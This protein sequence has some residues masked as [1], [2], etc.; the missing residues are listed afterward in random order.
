ML[1]SLPLEI[2]NRILFECDPIDISSFSQVCRL[3]RNHVYGVENRTH[4]WHLIFLNHFDPSIY[5]LHQ[6]PV[7]GKGGEVEGDEDLMLK[8]RQSSGLSLQTNIDWCQTVQRRIKLRQTLSCSDDKELLRRLEKNYPAGSLIEIYQEISQ[9]IL[10]SKID[11]QWSYSQDPENQLSQSSLNLTFLRNILSYPPTQFRIILYSGQNSQNQPLFALR[12]TLNNRLVSLAAELHTKYGLTDFDRNKPR[13]RG[14]ARESC[15]ALQN[16]QASSLYGPFMPDRSCRVNWAHLE[17]LSVVVGL[18]LSLAKTSQ[19]SSIEEVNRHVQGHGRTEV[20]RTTG[21]QQFI[22]NNNHTTN[23]WQNNPVGLNNLDQSPDGSIDRRFL[24]TDWPILDGLS[25]ARPFTQITN[26]AYQHVA[27]DWPSNELRMNRALD[28]NHYDWA[29]VEGKWLRAVCFLDYRDLHAYNFGPRDT[30]KVDNYKEAIRLM[31]L[32]LKVVSIG[33]RP[34]SDPSHPEPLCLQ[35][36]PQY[37]PPIYFKGSATSSV[38]VGSQ[39]GQVRGCV[40]CTKDKQVRWS[41]VRTAAGQDRWSSEGIQVGGIRSK[42]GVLGVWTDVDRNDV[43]GPA[44]PFY[45]F[46]ISY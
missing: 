26:P 3:T 23:P 34:A 44:G 33:E 14:I 7:M 38:N 46:K 27:Y 25:S 6:Q 42:W 4:L 28:L 1:E 22:D 17:A 41:V 20:L 24:E 18:N 30:R 13:T 8:S 19:S 5:S 40:S 10:T 15:Y 43:E 12:P 32:N 2:L 16:Y 11:S 35:N 37:L 21:Y 39:T 9:I 36:G 45:F 29:G 31:T